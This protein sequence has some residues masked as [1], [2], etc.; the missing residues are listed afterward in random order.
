VET[1]RRYALDS[2]RTVETSII[3]PIATTVSE[4]P[5][6]RATRMRPDLTRLLALATALGGGKGLLLFRG[7]CFDGEYYLACRRVVQ[8]LL[9][10]RPYLDAGIDRSFEVDLNVKPLDSREVEM[11][12][13]QN[14]ISRLVWRPDRSY[15]YDCVQLLRDPTGDDRLVVILNYSAQ[16]LQCGVRVRGLFDPFYTLH[17][18]S[19]GGEPGRYSRL[20]VERGALDVTVPARDC[21]FL[22]LK[23]VPQDD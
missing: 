9:D 22:Q 6:Y 23:A 20:D 16:P 1:I 21:L 2:G 10:I 5:R 17:D 7:D 18:L 15:Q 8:E 3:S 4:M 13:A 11:E 12:M 14:L 19:A